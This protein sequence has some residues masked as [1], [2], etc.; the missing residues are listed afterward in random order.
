MLVTDR[1]I[2][3]RPYQRPDHYFFGTFDNF[4]MWTKELNS[5]QISDIYHA[6]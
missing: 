5:T 3:G 2:F 4:L 6:G 1:L